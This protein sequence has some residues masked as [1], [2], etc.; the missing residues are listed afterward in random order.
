MIRTVLQLRATP[1]RAA[2]LVRVFHEQKVLEHSRAMPGCQAVE[3]FRSLDDPD[4]SVVF[5]DWDDVDAYER[6]LANP[7]RPEMTDALRPL[8]AKAAAGQIV[9]GRYQPA[10]TD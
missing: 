8:L 10:A 7:R 3:I 6:W 4:L 2:E 9:G 1:G 5:A